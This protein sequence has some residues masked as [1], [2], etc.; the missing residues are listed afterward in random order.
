GS[1]ENSTPGALRRASIGSLRPSRRRGPQVGKERVLQV[2]DERRGRVPVVGGAV[3]VAHRRRV[4]F[5]GRGIVQAGHVDADECAAHHFE[6]CPAEDA[7]AAVAAEAVLDRARAK[8]VT[9]KARAALKQFEGLGRNVRLP[10]PGL[11]AIAAVA[12]QG[13]VEPWPG[14]PLRGA[15]PRRCEID[16]AAE[17]DAAAMAA[18]VAMSDH[19]RCSGC[20][21]IFTT[22]SGAGDR[23]A[24]RA[25]LHH[26]GAAAGLPA[27]DAAGSRWYTASRKRLCR[28]VPP[29]GMDCVNSTATMSLAGSTQNRVLA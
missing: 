3:L 2:G 7:G 13:R 9:A 22:C 26:Y 16:L 29:G 27:A 23:Q 11:A 28:S 17:P 21:V 8:A 5:G 6:V 1:R 12:A 24:V 4:Q 19:A 20:G 25:R 18:A 14:P 15:L 10:D